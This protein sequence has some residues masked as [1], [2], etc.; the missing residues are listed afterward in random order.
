MYPAL[1]L[2]EQALNAVAVESSRGWRLAKEKSS[3]K[4]DAI[5]ALA[6]A[7]HEAITAGNLSPQFGTGVFHQWQ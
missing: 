5:V 4:I 3:K 6:M 1:D 7:C 2:R